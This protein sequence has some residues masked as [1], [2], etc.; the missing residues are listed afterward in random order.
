[1]REKQGRLCGC[2]IRF[3]AG[4]NTYWRY[5]PGIFFDVE[6]AS[7]FAEV[8]FRAI[9][10]TVAKVV[11]R[12]LF[13]PFILINRISF[14]ICPSWF[15]LCLPLYQMLDAGRCSGRRLSVTCY[16]HPTPSIS[17]PVGALDS[18]A[19]TGNSWFFMMFFQ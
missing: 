19:K 2:R 11:A 8:V 4:K 10:A 18:K 17:L 16:K 14:Q 9:R 5:L 1:M 6:I 12:F 15:P 7:C 13:T 3:P